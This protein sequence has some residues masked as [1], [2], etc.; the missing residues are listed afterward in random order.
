M[1]TVEDSSDQ[2]PMTEIDL[3][4]DLRGVPP[5]KKWLSLLHSPRAEAVVKAYVKNQ[6]LANGLA[7]GR[8]DLSWSEES[9]LAIGAVLDRLSSHLGLQAQAIGQEDGASVRNRELLANRELRKQER[10]LR[11]EAYLRGKSGAKA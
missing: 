6:F 4:I 10:I 9:L 1:P 7:L 11:R 2:I 3:G 5:S 8:Q